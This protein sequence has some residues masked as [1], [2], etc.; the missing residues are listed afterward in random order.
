MLASFAPAF[1]ELGGTLLDYQNYEP[2]AQD[3]SFEIEN[4]MGLR[5]S[6]QRYERLRANIGSTY[7]LC[8]A[9]QTS[10]KRRKTTM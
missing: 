10:S 7:A 1:E 2:N 9:L 6:T 3:F 8:S 5:Q 4:L